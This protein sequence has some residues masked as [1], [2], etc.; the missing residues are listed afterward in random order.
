V[1]EANEMHRLSQ[2]IPPVKLDKIKTK[3]HNDYELFLKQDKHEHDLLCESLYENQGHYCAYC[4]TVI[5]SV[6]NG[7]LEHLE[8]RRDNPKRS[9]DWT[10]MFFSCCHED[11]C[12]KFKDDSKPNIVFNIGDIIDPHTEDPQDFFAY[13]MQGHI[14][15]K[16]GLPD[17]EKR[18]A[19]ETIRVF[20]LNSSVRLVN[21][22]RNAAIS[23]CPML[24]DVTTEEEIDVFLSVLSGQDC[25]SVYYA[26]LNRRM[27]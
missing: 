15:P 23:A 1:K 16:S 9:F 26:L 3:F 7:H 14:F 25:I 18:R 17:S 5:H 13:D 20:N 12:G 19:E 4:E 27:P 2:G 21:I 10:N 11:S 24:Q 22:R 8:R 6:T